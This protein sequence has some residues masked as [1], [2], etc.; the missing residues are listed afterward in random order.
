VEAW[1]SLSYEDEQPEM[2]RSR[3]PGPFQAR[4]GNLSAA[5]GS[6]SAH[7]SAMP[8]TARNSSGGEHRIQLFLQAANVAAADAVGQPGGHVLVLRLRIGDGTAALHVTGG[9]Q[10]ARPGR[11]ARLP[12]RRAGWDGQRV[13]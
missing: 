2:R 3:D 4:G 8:A 13:G 11:H 12:G 6:S 7:R 1:G 5:V 9:K 10:A